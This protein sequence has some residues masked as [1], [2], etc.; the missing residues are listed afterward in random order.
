[1]KKI[2]ALILTDT[3]LTKS[4]YA[5]VRSIFEQAI[6]ICKEKD[7]KRI[8]HI[9]DFFTSRE[10]QPLNVL[11]EAQE[12]FS[13]IKKSG[14]KLSIV[15]GNHDKVSLESEDSYLDVFDKDCILIKKEYSEEVD[16][17]NICWLPYF[18]EKGSYSKRLNNI[19]DGIIRHKK[20]ILLT[21]IAIDGVS[22]NDSSPV[23]NDIKRTLFKEFDK[24]LCGHYHF[25]QNFEN[26]YYIG[27]SHASN[28]GEDSMKGFTLLYDDAS[29][30]F[31]KSK[32]PEYIKI[33]VD[34]DDKKQLL[35]LEKKHANSKDNVRFV[36]TGNKEKLQSFKKDGL[37]G[38]GIDIKFE[39]D[40]VIVSSNNEKVQVYDRSNL[41]VAFDKFVLANEIK[42]KEFGENYLE[43]I[44]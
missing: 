44:L 17:L 34:V 36:L 24:V 31:I 39:S 33:K 18:K 19:T 35:E 32:F 29:I 22:N 2:V 12:I 38:K 26:I 28:F 40:D 14:I 43:K 41:K 7:I 5:L 6:D 25:Q 9:G 21:H 11:L 3:H 10:A 8:Y 16:G 20:N 13:M 30:E 27:S 1:M 15:A 37:V 42:D 23:E 4:N